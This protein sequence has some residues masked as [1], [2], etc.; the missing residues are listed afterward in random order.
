VD[1]Y[2]ALLW[3][4]SKALRYGTRSQ[5]ISEFYLQTPRTSANGMNLCP[6]PYQPKLVLI[7]T[8]IV[9]DRSFAS[10]VA[11]SREWYTCVASC[12][13]CD[14][15]FYT[16]F[17]HGAFFPGG[18]AQFDTK[19]A[20]LNEFAQLQTPICAVETWKHDRVKRTRRDALSELEVCQNAFAFPPRTPLGELT[21]LPRSPSW[22]YRRGGEGQ[23]TG[24]DSGGVGKRGREEREG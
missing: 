1:L 18:G 14:G 19:C 9:S 5:G 24:K 11:G 7:Y 15:F 8:I 3:H 13:A 6:L 2:S 20:V 17:R 16:R 23:G 21:V 10:P 12:L 22:I 4:T